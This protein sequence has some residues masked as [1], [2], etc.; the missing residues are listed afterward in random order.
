MDQSEAGL[1]DE[2]EDGP[3]YKVDLTRGQLGE[4]YDLLVTGGFWGSGKRGGYFGSFFCA[5]LDDSN[6][7][8]PRYIQSNQVAAG[9]MALS[10]T[11]ASARS[12]PACRSTT[13]RQS[14]RRRRAN[15]S[16]SR[17]TRS[18]LQIWCSAPKSRTNGSRPRSSSSRTTFRLCSSACSSVILSVKAAEIVQDGA[19]SDCTVSGSVC[20]SEKLCC[21]P[22]FEVPESR[23]LRI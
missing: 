23:V 6:E 22:L 21:W 11:S 7:N 1:Y 19:C 14:A 2:R 15:G 5:L 8:N 16:R 13:S 9:L 17:K 18:T 20:A 4:N 10:D 12:D 3:S